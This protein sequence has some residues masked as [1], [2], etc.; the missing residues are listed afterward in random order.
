VALGPDGSVFIA[1]AAGH[2]IRRVW[3]NGS[4]STVAKN[5]LFEIID[6]PSGVAV[7]SEGEVIFADSLASRVCRVSPQGSV[8]TVHF[9][10]SPQG[11]ALGPDGAIYIADQLAE[12]VVRVPKG[13]E[14]T[15]VA[16]S[17]NGGWRG[18]GLPATKARLDAPHG[19]AVAPDGSIYIADSGNHR[20]H[21]VSPDGVLTTVAGNGQPPNLRR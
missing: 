8:S 20:I 18:D 10:D 6:G 7:T 19:V 15:T 16:G 5:S 3:P 21:R 12:K 11:V 1:E 14:T 17:G 2:R 13:G 4:I 9:G